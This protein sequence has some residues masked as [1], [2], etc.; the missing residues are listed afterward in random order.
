MSASFRLCRRFFVSDVL[1]W[2]FFY[3][4]ELWIFD[5][6]SVNCS[7][8]KDW[9]LTFV[10]PSFW[11][12]YVPDLCGILPD[13]VRNKCAIKARR[14]WLLVFIW[15]ERKQYPEREWKSSH[16][17]ETVCFWRGMLK[18]VA[19]LMLIFLFLDLLQATPTQQSSSVT[20]LKGLGPMCMHVVKIPFH[21]FEKFSFSTCVYCALS[22][23]KYIN[24][25]HLFSWPNSF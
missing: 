9:Y 12:N 10:M 16:S 11:L 25:I 15:L 8:F 7:N 6:L 19:C 18:H 2:A 14:V 5:T 17:N 20:T 1:K 21:C 4:I 22:S 24:N 13:V 3:F 23:C